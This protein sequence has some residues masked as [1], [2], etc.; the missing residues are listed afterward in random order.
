VVRERGQKQAATLKTAPDWALIR[1][2]TRI[3]HSAPGGG[4]HRDELAERLHLPA[5]GPVL[6]EALMIA[7]RN[8]KIDFC[9]QY[10]VKPCKPKET[11]S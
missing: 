8:R 2:I 10:V 5:R 9:R 1:T 7:Y 3:V 11:A 4:L 6:T